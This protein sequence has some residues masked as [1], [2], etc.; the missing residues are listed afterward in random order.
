[1]LLKLILFAHFIVVMHYSISLLIFTA[2]DS[3]D[4]LTRLCD[5]WQT[6]EPKE[7]GSVELPWSRICWFVVTTPPA[8]L[9]GS[10]EVWR[11]WQ[12]I[13]WSS[14]QCNS[15]PHTGKKGRY[16]CNSTT[17]AGA[18]KLNIVHLTYSHLIF[19]LQACNSHGLSRTG[20][21]PGSCT[22]S[23][24][25][26]D[27]SVLSDPAHV[28]HPSSILATVFWVAVSLMESDF[29]FEYQMSLRLVHK[30]LSKVD[31]MKFTN[32][33]GEL[34]WWWKKKIRTWQHLNNILL[35]WV[36]YESKSHAKS[37]TLMLAE[38]RL[39]WV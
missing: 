14:S 10:Q 25:R 37:L 16:L 2:F 38:Y 5:Q 28:S 34:I 31:K 3:Q 18:H 36:S 6:N 7:H 24:N 8:L 12:P 26:I 11:V 29:E 20:R 17:H 33:K 4:V 19:N 15:R 21:T 30:L 27:P 9:L 13:K 39:L 32:L 23:T 22:S 35:T 1:M